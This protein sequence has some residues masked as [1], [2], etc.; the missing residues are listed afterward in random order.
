MLAVKNLPPSTGD[1]GD[2]GLIP[3]SGRSPGVGNGNSLQYSCQENPMDRGAWRATVY[4]VTKSWTWLKGLSMH[5]SQLPVKSLAS[6]PYL[7]HLLG[8]LSRRGILACLREWSN[9][10]RTFPYQATNLAPWI[11]L[12][13]QATSCSSNPS[14]ICCLGCGYTVLFL[15]WSSQAHPT[16]VTYASAHGSE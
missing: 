7:F 5:A 6:Q 11:S 15:P 12:R 9:I 4:G 8:S 2:V 13:I 14:C 10:E 3:G 1:A 16:W